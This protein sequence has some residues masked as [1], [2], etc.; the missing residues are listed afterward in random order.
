[1]AFGR[2]PR[3]TV[4]R[5]LYFALAG[6]ILFSVV[7]WMNAGGEDKRMVWTADDARAVCHFLAARQAEAAL[8]RDGASM[9]AERR[10]AVA[11]EA[12]ASAREVTWSALNKMHSGMP[13]AYRDYYQASLEQT[14]AA[15]QGEAEAAQRAQ[16]LRQSWLEWFRNEREAVRLPSSVAESCR[17][18]D[19]TRAG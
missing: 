14:V 11:Q 13:D 12:L 1:M 16:A 18:D 7:G 19:V 17:P 4:G 5:V 2:L 8:Q 6:F 9:S 10:L 3:M 15:L